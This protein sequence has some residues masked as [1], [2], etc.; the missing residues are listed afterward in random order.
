MRPGGRQEN[1]S[2]ADAIRPHEVTRK[3]C[4]LFNE[5]EEHL[6]NEARGEAR[7][8]RRMTDPKLPTAE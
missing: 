7:T 2:S 3:I 8:V 1:E 5:D 6:E 4:G